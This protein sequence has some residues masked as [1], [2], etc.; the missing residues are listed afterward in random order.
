MLGVCLV[1]G[2]MRAWAIFGHVLNRVRSWLLGML[3]VLLLDET[4][5]EFGGGEEG[6][7]WT[8]EGGGVGFFPFFFAISV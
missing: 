7:G 6:I 2:W 3:L 8:K 1:R 5:W 4:K